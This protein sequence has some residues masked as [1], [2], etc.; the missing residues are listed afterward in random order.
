MVRHFIFVCAYFIL[1][2]FPIENLLFFHCDFDN[3]THILLIQSRFEI[4]LKINNIQFE[5][6]LIVHNV[7]HWIKW[8]LYSIWTSIFQ[9][10]ESRS[11]RLLCIDFYSVLSIPCLSLELSKDEKNSNFVRSSFHIALLKKFWR[12]KPLYFSV[13]LSISTTTI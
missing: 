5:S 2:W 8:N 6:S 3:I 4:M 1:Q 7:W 11:K 12:E 9:F 13:R 10:Q